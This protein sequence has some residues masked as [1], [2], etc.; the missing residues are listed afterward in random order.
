LGIGGLAAFT[1]SP[2]RPAEPR[3]AVL[4]VAG[5]EWPTSDTGF[6]EAGVSTP[7]FVR[8]ICDSFTGGRP[9]QFLLYSRHWAYGKPFQQ[10]LSRLGHRYQ[11]TQEPGPL[12]GYDGVFL[13]GTNGINREAVLEY[14]LEGGCVYL[15][16]GTGDRP[17]D[18]AFWNPLLKRFGMEYQ[19]DR[20]PDKLDITEF[21]EPGLFTGVRSLH[22]RGGHHIN[23]LP[24]E[25]PHTRVVARQAEVN[26][27]AVYSQRPLGR[28]PNV[29]TTRR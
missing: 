9:G 4:I 12:K 7:R 18:D 23:L 26:W 11:M 16:G 5:D 17:S 28:R 13:A 22:T 20:G 10:T 1:P 2:A 15:A 3:N 27:W 24:G 14:L 6:H 29:Q 21:A 8:N 19:G 25:W